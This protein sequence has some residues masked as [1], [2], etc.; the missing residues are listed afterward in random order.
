MN[1][2]YT[3]SIL[4]KRSKHTIDRINTILNT[5]FA[6]CHNLGGRVE[7]LYQRVV[8]NDVHQATMNQGLIDSLAGAHQK[9]KDLQA[10]QAILEQRLALLERGA[11]VKIEGD[12][13][14][15]KEV[16]QEPMN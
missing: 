3:F 16:K 10:Q 4:S 13:D 1:L 15:K 2:P 5:L 14:V 9:I 12:G 7:H 6:L 8:R 11:G